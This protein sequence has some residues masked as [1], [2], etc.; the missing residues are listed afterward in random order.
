MLAGG[1]LLAVGLVAAALGSLWQGAAH[2]H[3]YDLPYA[4]WL[5]LY[6]PYWPFIPY[7]PLFIMIP[8]VYLI[9]RYRPR[10]P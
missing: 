9:A 7:L 6:F 8:G 4:L 5:D 2:Q 1:L 10:T 3:L